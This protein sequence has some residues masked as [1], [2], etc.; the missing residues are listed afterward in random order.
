MV[1]ATE[2]ASQPHPTRRAP[3]LDRDIDDERDM[4]ILQT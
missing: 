1:R 2:A 4:V 3:D